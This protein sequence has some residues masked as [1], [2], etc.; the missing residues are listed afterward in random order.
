MG[1]L[2]TRRAKD[3]YERN[4][5]VVMDFILRMVC[6]KS[7]IW[8]RKGRKKRKRKKRR[9]KKRKKRRRRRR[10]KKKRKR[11]KRCDRGRIM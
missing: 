1:L 8:R 7:R 3:T 4:V 2:E 11:R 9:R 10:K 5:R 6:R